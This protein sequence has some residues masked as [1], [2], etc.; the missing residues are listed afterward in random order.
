MGYALAI[1]F[2]IGVLT[3]PTIGWLRKQFDAWL[4]VDGLQERK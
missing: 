2:V 3:W 1:A 4:E